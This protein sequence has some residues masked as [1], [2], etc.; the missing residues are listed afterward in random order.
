[1]LTSL[2]TEI[3]ARR[4]LKMKANSLLDIGEDGPLAAVTTQT[5]LAL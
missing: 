2:A 1:M 4:S 5:R 3:E